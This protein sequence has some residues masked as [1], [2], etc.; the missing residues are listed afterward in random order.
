MSTYKWRQDA[1]YL[2]SRKNLLERKH[3]PFINEM[4][5]TASQPTFKQIKYLK[6]LMWEVE[7]KLAGKWV[8]QNKTSNIQVDRMPVYAQGCLDLRHWSS[9]RLTSR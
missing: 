8:T 2:L 3:Y 9:R 5:A 4:A 1:L 6:G 7:K